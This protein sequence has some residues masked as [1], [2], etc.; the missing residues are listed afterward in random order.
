MINFSSTVIDWDIIYTEVIP[1]L[2][3]QL[4]VSAL[5]SVLAGALGLGVGFYFLWFGIRKGQAALKKGFSRGK[6]G[7]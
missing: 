2:S 4:S 5:I 6:V 1:S 3:A 7:V